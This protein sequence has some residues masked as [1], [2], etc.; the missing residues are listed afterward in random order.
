MSYDGG[1]NFGLLGDYDALPDIDAF[2]AGL[3]ESL[4]ELR[5]AAAKKSSGRK[6][7]TAPTGRKKPGARK[8]GPAAE[9]RAKRRGKTSSAAQRNGSGAS[10]ARSK[11]APS[12]K[13]S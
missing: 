13:R 1:V 4:L 8:S 5:R 9:M 12:A 10:P 2:A 11:R 3:E 7:A 6:A